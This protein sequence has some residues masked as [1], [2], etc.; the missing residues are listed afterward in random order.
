LLGQFVIFKTV[1]T[2]S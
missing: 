2:A 1:K